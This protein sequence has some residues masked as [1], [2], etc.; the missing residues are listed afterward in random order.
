MKMGHFLKSTSQ[1]GVKT[2]LV[3]FRSSHSMLT[4]YVG[5]S[6]SVG[7]RLAFSSAFSQ[8]LTRVCS[9]LTSGVITAAKSNYL[10]R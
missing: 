2:R 5:E 1:H 9:E 8:Q 7:S 3:V 6:L 10:T 4:D